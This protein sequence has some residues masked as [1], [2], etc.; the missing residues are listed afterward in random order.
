MALDIE[1]EP[2]DDLPCDRSLT[3]AR[4]VAATGYRLPT[5]DEMI[6]E[7]RRD[8][9]PYDDWRRRHDAA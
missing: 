7:L 6:A 3:P 4:F 5:W 2:D 8:P 9:T 1:I